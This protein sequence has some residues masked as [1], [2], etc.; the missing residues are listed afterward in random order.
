MFESFNSTPIGKFF[1]LEE[2]GS[3]VVTEFRGGLATFLSMA[4]ILAVNPRILSESGGPCDADDYADSGGIFSAGYEECMED[5]KRQMITATA[6]VSIFGT[7]LMGLGANLPIALS[8]GMGMNAYF[9]Y[10]VVGW[11]GGGDVTYGQALSA[12]A[13]EGA[14]FFILAVT[15]CRGFIVKFIPEC[16]RYSTPAGIGF[17]LAH[18]GLQTA[19]GIGVVVGDIATAV[20]LGGCPLENRVPMVAYDDTCAN[21]GICVTSDNY[22][23]DVFDGKM[24]SAPTW[25]G[26]GGGLL[27]VIL[28][29]YKVH[30][31][32]II[33]ISFVT[34]ISWF[35]GTNVSYFEDGVFNTGG[36]GEA[37]YD[38]FVKIVNV[39]SMDK[40][41]G[42]YSDDL[43]GIATALFTFLYVDFLDTSGTLFGLANQ[44]NI[45]DENGDFP[46]STAAFSADALSTI[47]ASI[48]GMSP[49]TS[50]IE[51]AAGVEAGAKTGLS[52]MF[53][54]FFFFLSIFFAPILASIPPWASGSALIL[55]GV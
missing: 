46:G 54:A 6:L 3:D 20:T 37:R 41:T 53:V 43:N 48:F 21:L 45:V 9:T 50:Y 14:I 12:I 15:G 33:G 28:L 26:I 36:S 17:F 52:N 29:C 44:M 55:A 27:M 49:V 19:E 22:T 8:T 42:E 47:F 38:Y 25:L 39:E 16:V 4:Y 2:R 24:T 23:C 7:L 34:I 40:I 1:K 18:L 31:S 30:S 13:I 11:R 5:V 32:F 35:R 51:S 10:D